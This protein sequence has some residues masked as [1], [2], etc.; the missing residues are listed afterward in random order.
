MLYSFTFFPTLLLLLTLFFFVCHVNSHGSEPLPRDS[1]IRQTPSTQSNHIPRILKI[2]GNVSQK[3]GRMV[4]ISRATPVAQTAFASPSV[5]KALSTHNL[6]IHSDFGF[7]VDCFLFT[8]VV[9]LFYPAV[10]LLAKEL[11]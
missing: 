2:S 7:T 9:N 8:S 11:T 4:H 1:H 3:F 6:L 5:T 10:L